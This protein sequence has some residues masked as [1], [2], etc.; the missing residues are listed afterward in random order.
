MSELVSSWGVARRAA[1]PPFHVMEVLSAAARRQRD[2]GD[3]V[4]LAAGQ[5]SSPAPRPVRAA[6]EE[7]LRRHPLGYTEQLGILELREA[8]AGHYGSRYGLDV[9]P[10]DV[11]I[12]TGSSGGF[13]LAFLAAFDAGDR[14]ALARP[15]YPAYRNILTALGCEV[16][17]L[18]CGPDTRF[19]PTVSMLEA[20]DTPIRG[21]V[22]ASPNN[23]T[24]TVLD[25]AELA[26][27][28]N[29]C[30]ANGVRLVSDEIYHGISYGRHLTSAWESST[31]AVV[32]NSFSK[33]F[34]MTGWRLGWLLA[35]R[36]LV[37]AID[38]LTGNFTLCPPA[39]AQHAAVAA[40]TT[41]SY[42]EA[43][44]H[45]ARYRTNRDLLVEGLRKLGIERVA[46]ADG[47]FYAYADVSHLTDDSMAFCQRLLD[48]TGVAIVPGVDFDP[49]DGGRFV[50]LSFAGSTEDVAEALGRLGA[51][52]PTLG[53]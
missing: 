14:V 47:A 22:V 12:T 43:D 10:D 40:F 52:L 26:A 15:G 5:P 17:E 37:R 29:W 16:V 39:L 2:K 41:E 11:V 45:V 3:V 19:Q 50:R 49:V 1:V 31:N 48:E 20:L 28:A 25:P 13:L 42:A 27:L 36:E 51:W 21:L 35:P 44:A 53:H 7:A 46:P 34:A 32:V 38:R 33:Y 4:S 30:D 18:P 6:A 9:A 8:V 24:G 23:P